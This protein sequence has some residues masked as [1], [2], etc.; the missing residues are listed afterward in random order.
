ML[1]SGIVAYSYSTEFYIAFFSKNEFEMSQFAYRATGDYAWAFWIMISCNCIFP[2]LFWFK[3][4]RTN[5]PALFVIT[6]LVNVGMWFE[7]FNIIAQSLSHEF[8]PSAFGMMRPSWVEMG[9]LLGSFC[10]F[11]TLFL[12]CIKL[13]PAMALT[14]LKELLPAPTKGGRHE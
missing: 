4:I 3:K 5:I 9:I 6:V 10:W 14:E 1:T 13:V 8:D 7:R 2:L 11:L 12:A